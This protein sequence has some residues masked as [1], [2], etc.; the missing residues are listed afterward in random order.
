MSWT[1]NNQTVSFSFSTKFM[2]YYFRSY[3][4]AATLDKARSSVA[5]AKPGKQAANAGES[6]V[7]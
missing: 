6:S 7:I 1:E 4:Y 2:V 3:L 5:S